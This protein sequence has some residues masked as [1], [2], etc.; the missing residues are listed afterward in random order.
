MKFSREVMPLRVTSMP[1]FLIL[2][3]QP[4]QNE[5]DEELSAV[6][7]GPLNSVWS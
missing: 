1:Y 7:A 6:S 4:F 5:I 2:S 3:L